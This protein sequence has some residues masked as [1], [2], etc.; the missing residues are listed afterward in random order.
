M[1]EKDIILP[2]CLTKEDIIESNILENVTDEDVEIIRK[3]LR[4]GLDAHFSMIF[5]SVLWE[6]KKEK[7][8]LQKKE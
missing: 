3:K 4:N 2:F 1:N 6:Y 7:E 5:A 8:N